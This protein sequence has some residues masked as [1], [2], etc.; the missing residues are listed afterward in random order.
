MEIFCMKESN[1]CMQESIL[2]TVLKMDAIGLQMKFLEGFYQMEDERKRRC[3]PW[4]GRPDIILENLEG[5]Q[6]TGQATGQ[7]M[8]MSELVPAVEAARELAE[9]NFPQY[10][11]SPVYLCAKGEL[12]VGWFQINMKD[13]EIEHIKAF[14][15]I[16]DEMIMLTFTYPDTEAIKWKSIILHSFGTWRAFHGEN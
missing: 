8:K 7:E 9:N 12:S 16:N 5:V 11:F 14:S 4:K 3:Y 2:L 13:R 1:G 15:V 10:S 6:V